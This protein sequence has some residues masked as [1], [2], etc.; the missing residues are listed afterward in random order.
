[1]VRRERPV[2]VDRALRQGAS[3][4]AD[5]KEQQPVGGQREGDRIAEKQEDDQ[6][7]NMIGAMFTA[8]NSIMSPRCRSSP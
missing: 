5:D 8:M 6:R 2:R 3:S 4:D 1:M 7:A